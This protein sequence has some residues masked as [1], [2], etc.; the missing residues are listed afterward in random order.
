MKSSPNYSTSPAKKIVNVVT[1]LPLGSYG[2]NI[3]CGTSTNLSPYASNTDFEN[4]DFFLPIQVT[5]GRHQHIV[6]SGIFG[7]ILFI[8]WRVIYFLL[9]RF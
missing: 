3:R 8:V 9:V 6:A 4:L 5:F 2:H 7:N 1:F